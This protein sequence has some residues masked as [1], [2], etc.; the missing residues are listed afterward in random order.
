M[1]IS[2]HFADLGTEVVRL[3]VAHG[4]TGAIGAACGYA[5]RLY[6]DHRRTKR[7]G[8]DVVDFFGPRDSKILIV[9]TAILDPSR[10]AY[11]FPSCDTRASR[12]IARLFDSTGMSEGKDFQIISE[13]EYKAGYVPNSSDCNLVLL[14]GPKRNSLVSEVLG[15]TPFL[16][17][18][19]SRSPTGENVLFDKERNSRFESSRDLEQSSPV[20]NGNYDFGLLLS[21]PNPLSP[22]TRLVVLSGIHGTGTLGAALFVSD[23]SRLASL[24]RRRRKGIVQEV[25]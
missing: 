14:C 17:Y 24:C 19:L 18:Q 7:I 8:H 11:N 13:V 2:L 25:Q 10:K 9:H 23:P 12:A 3:V 20:S 21:I 6:Q 1:P 22:N 15:L 16:R 4:I 5:F